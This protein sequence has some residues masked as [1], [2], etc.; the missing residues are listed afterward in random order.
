VLY[1]QINGDNLY[2]KES[3]DFP[4]KATDLIVKKKTNL[5]LGT[6]YKNTGRVSV[7]VSSYPEITR[8]NYTEI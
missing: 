4:K 3:A 6:G 8:L 5:K 1:F 7:L 2:E